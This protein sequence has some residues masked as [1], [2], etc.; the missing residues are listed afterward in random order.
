MCE[1]N[2]EIYIYR[3]PWRGDKLQDAVETSYRYVFLVSMNVRY[4]TIKDVD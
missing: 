4:G 3:G 2:K 1:K